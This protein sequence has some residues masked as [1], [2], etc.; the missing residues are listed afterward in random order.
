M[1]EDIAAAEYRSLRGTRRNRHFRRSV[2]AKSLSGS[3]ESTWKCKK[4]IHQSVLN[5]GLVPLA[6][7][8][9]T[10]LKSEK[11]SCT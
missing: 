1:D 11:N 5:S 3:H 6:M 7:D 10:S 9:I 4:D 8:N 2:P